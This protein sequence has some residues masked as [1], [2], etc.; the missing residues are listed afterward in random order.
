MKM[1]A[2]ALIFFC[3]SSSASAQET[4]PFPLGE[5]IATMISS[6]LSRQAERLLPV[7]SA[8]IDVVDAKA[9]KYECS[10][11]S[12]GLV[13]CM[14]SGS[15]LGFLYLNESATSVEPRAFEV[16]KKLR[17]RKVE[18]GWALVNIEEI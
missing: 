17:L 6:E 10:A 8:H 3:C 18:A 15:F 2:A 9:L 12:A 16:E 1:F 14:V 7:L 11:P 13:D 5:D 4:G